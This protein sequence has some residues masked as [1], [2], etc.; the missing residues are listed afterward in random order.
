VA[1]A[2]LGLDTGETPRARANASFR[3]AAAASTRAT[4][5]LGSARVRR[6]AYEHWR[7][8][9][10]ATG[11]PAAGP[12]MVLVLTERRLLVCRASFWTGRAS[13]PAGAVDLSEIAQVATTR[14]AALVALAFALA[15][16]HVVEVEAL[17]GR[18]LRRLAHALQAALGDRT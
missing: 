4:F 16:G 6:D 18:R 3:G 14:H 5:S 7:D 9:A 12:E 1:G 17:R 15:N 8:A 11:F 10:A 13:T 2:R